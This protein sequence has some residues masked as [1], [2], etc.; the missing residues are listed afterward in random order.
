[1]VFPFVLFDSP[2]FWDVCACSV[3]IVLLPLETWPF[4]GC[5]TWKPVELCDVS[6]CESIC[7]CWE[8]GGASDRV[9]ELKIET[10][11]HGP[12]PPYPGWHGDK[13]GLCHPKWPQQGGRVGKHGKECS[14]ELKAGWCPICH[15][16][17]QYSMEDLVQ[18][19]KNDGDKLLEVKSNPRNSK[20]RNE[21]KQMDAKGTF[22]NLIKFV[23]T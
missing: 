4:G 19:V 17:L 10:F 22:M 2:S 13:P 3:C 14:F 16:C 9:D 5:A 18:C 15:I 21:V 8:R 6:R 12:W 20:L 7:H 1:M 11:F 23:Y